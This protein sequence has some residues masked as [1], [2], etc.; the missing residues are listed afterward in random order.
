M[1]AMTLFVGVALRLALPVAFM[2][3]IS[4]RLRAWDAKGGVSW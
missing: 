3:W 2:F 4:A 1:E